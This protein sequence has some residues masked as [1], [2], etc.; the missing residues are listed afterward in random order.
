MFNMAYIN[1]SVGVGGEI[2][3]GLCLYYV[4]SLFNC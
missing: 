3:A 2:S 4:K 1:P